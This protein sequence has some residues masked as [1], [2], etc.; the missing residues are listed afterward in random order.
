M[1]V[2]RVTTD[3]LSFPSHSFL[4]IVLDLCQ[5]KALITVD[6]NSGVEVQMWDS[7]RL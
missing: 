1:R 7:I 4:F 2:D 5:F 6:R 3:P